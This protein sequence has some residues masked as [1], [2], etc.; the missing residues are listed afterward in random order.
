MIWESLT[1][2]LHSPGTRPTLGSAPSRYGEDRYLPP[3]R[4]WRRCRSCSAS[5]CPDSC[6][7]TPGLRVSPGLNPQDAVHQRSRSMPASIEGGGDQQRHNTTTTLPVPIAEPLDASC[8][9]WGFCAPV[10]RIQ[11]RLVPF[12]KCLKPIKSLWNRIWFLKCFT[13]CRRHESMHETLPGT[14]REKSQRGLEVALKAF[15][16]VGMNELLPAIEKNLGFP[17]Q[18]FSCAVEASPDRRSWPERLGSLDVAVGGNIFTITFKGRGR[19]VGQSRLP[20]RTAAAPFDR[21]G[22][23]GLRP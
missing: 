16:V 6:D 3:C 14:T 23:A 13:G 19:W 20:A 21:Q 18:A 9:Q 4:A 12:P 5:D 7:R 11:Q 17:A 22:R 8:I 1:R 15:V 10:L 2:A